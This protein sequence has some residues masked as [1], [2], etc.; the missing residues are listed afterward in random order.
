MAKYINTIFLKDPSYTRN[1]PGKLLSGTK[2]KTIFQIENL[3]Q[4]YNRY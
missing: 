3:N 4:N 1:N 2:Y